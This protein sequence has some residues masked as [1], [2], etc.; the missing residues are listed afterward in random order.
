MFI[1][2]VAANK[3]Q[4]TENMHSVICCVRLLQWFC[5]GTVKADVKQ[6]ALI[7]LP[8]KHPA[9]KYMYA[10]PGGS[11]ATTD[12]VCEQF[13]ALALTEFCFAVQ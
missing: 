12:D 11:L 13:G 5:F 8:I 2:R 10:G 1:N 6:L 7:Y 4:K 3:H 9:R